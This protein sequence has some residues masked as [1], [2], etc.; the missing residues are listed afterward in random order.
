MSLPVL[1]AIG[2]GGKSISFYYCSYRL[3]LSQCKGGG[4]E[5]FLIGYCA[6]VRNNCNAK[7]RSNWMAAFWFD[8]IN[9]NIHFQSI[10]LHFQNC[11]VKFF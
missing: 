1:N 3:F 8:P 10:H 7:P 11:K 2:D 4:G 9:A 5:S 6:I